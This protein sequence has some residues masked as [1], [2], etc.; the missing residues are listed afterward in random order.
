MIQIVKISAVP[1]ELPWVEGVNY[2]VVAGEPQAG[3]KVRIRSAAGESFQATYAPPPDPPPAQVPSQSEG[4]DL[5]WGEFLQ[6]GA[7]VSMAKFNAVLAAFPIAVE[8][9]RRYDQFPGIKFSDAQV[10][11][12]LLGDLIGGSV[13]ANIID[14]QDVEDTIA[15]WVALFP[16]M[17]TQN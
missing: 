8:L 7:K 16:M 15:M 14:A 2:E 1:T 4:R 10:P 17:V 12:T 13:Q 6:V 5:T 11:G 9:G 3:D